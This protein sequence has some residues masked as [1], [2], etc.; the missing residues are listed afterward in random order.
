MGNSFLIQRKLFFLSLGRSNGEIPIYIN[1][2]E[3]LCLPSGYI[4]AGTIYYLPDYSGDR[5]V[6]TD[7]AVSV[8][9]G[10]LDLIHG[11]VHLL[12]EL[13]ALCTMIR[14]HGEHGGHPSANNLF[15]S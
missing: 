3:M 9:A 7:K 5:S 14:I 11:F 13:V 8:L 10:L 12:D 4:V 2:E 1:N 15:S 6:L